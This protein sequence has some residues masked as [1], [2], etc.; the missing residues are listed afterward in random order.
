MFQISVHTPTP[1]PPEKV[2]SFLN[3][4]INFERVHQ[5]PYAKRVFKLDRMRELARRLG[6]LGRQIPIVHIAGTKGKG[7][8]SAL[9]CSVLKEAGQRVGSYTSPHLRDIGERISV[10]GADSSRE[11]LAEALAEVAPLVEAMEREATEEGNP[12]GGP[13]FFEILT[14]M[15][16]V[17]FHQARVDLGVLECGL[18]GRLDSTNVCS[19]VVTVITNIG[20]DHTQLLGNTLE[21]IAREK[22]GIIKPGVPLVSG[23]RAKEP[24]D[25]IRGVAAAL[26]APIREMGVDFTLRDAPGGRFSVQGTVAGEPY[27]YED[28]SL[29]LLG[30]HQ[31]ENAGLAVATIRELIAQGWHIPDEAVRRGLAAARCQGR[32]EVVASHPTV[33]VDV[34][35]NPAAVEA[36][37]ET[38]RESF[39]PARR[40]VVFGTSQDKDAET[41]LRLLYSY[42]DE[43]L[44]TQAKNQPRALDIDV[45]RSK[46]EAITGCSQTA[47]TF[48]DTHEAWNAAR[49]RSTSEDL[50]CVTGSFYI[51]GDFASTGPVSTDVQSSTI[52]EVCPP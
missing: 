28:L 25:A 18:G 8:V 15:A 49:T 1:F 41:M 24:R 46:A 13:T 3:A 22:A 43:V 50:I 2:D 6:D 52:T 11:D 23:V 20:Y 12:D 30:R 16:F 48:S 51:A 29:S 33:V 40:R 45:L 26:G 31:R 36:L 38:L 19:P 39:S 42:F 10:N 14:A 37:I 4:R 17:R 44:L 34:A 47:N 9:V 5:A 35:H 27:R 7:S 21:E 32:I